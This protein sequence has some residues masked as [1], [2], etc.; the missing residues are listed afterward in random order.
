MQ[1]DLLVT[2]LQIGL[3]GDCANLVWRFIPSK[4][5]AQNLANLLDLLR[6]YRGRHLKHGRQS[7]GNRLTMDEMILGSQ[8]VSF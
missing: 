2:E 6:Q 1:S 8:N 3:L 7:I 5:S 4:F